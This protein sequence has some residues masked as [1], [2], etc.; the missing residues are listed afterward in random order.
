[1]V[2][3]ATA[4]VDAS[5]QLPRGSTVALAVSAGP[6]ARIVPAGLV[7]EDVDS[8]RKQLTALKLGLDVTQAYSNQPVGQVLTTDQPD[9]A[10]VPRGTVVHVSVSQGPQPIP[11]PNVANMSVSDAS[12][13]LQAQGFVVSSVEGSPLKKVLATDP[14]AG[15]AHVPGTPVRLFTRN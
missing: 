5:G 4:P 3:S 6:A 2:I 7:G 1:V 12:T 9:N 13:A 8:V 11:I 15:E 14:P 10:S